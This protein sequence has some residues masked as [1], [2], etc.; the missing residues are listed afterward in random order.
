M[1]FRKGLGLVAV[2]A[3]AIAGGDLECSH[4]QQTAEQ[5]HGGELYERMCSVCHGRAGEGYKADQAPAL[6]N[7]A[8]L[9]TVTDEYLRAAITNGRH[10]TTMSAWARWHGGPLTQPDIESVVSFIHTWDPSARPALD[11]A[12]SRGDALRGATTFAS[13]CAKCH[14]AR[15][16]G[17]P[18]VNIGNP[19][20]LSMASNGFLRYAIR[21]GR[22][23]TAMPAF[24]PTLGD[25]KIEDLLAFLRNLQATAAPPPPA[26]PS[27]PPP[28]PLGPVP[29]NPKGPEPVG[30]HPSPATTP[31]EVIHAQLERGAKMAL[32]DARAPSDYTVQHIAGAVSVPFYDPG[33]YLALLPKDAWLVCYCACPHAESGQL[34]QRLVASGFSKVTVLNEGLGFW[35]SKGFPTHAG[36]AP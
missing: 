15:G 28:I 18:N 33:P 12:P 10:G 5:Q 2:I 36:T 32:L 3:T 8:F 14:G 30:F 22:Q 13:Q 16:T 17:G 34:A 19:Q 26:L 35:R 11:Q 9:G 20:L 31:A 4:V 27:R 21:Y 23:G 25:A 1:N 24:E 6:R 29:L 7:A